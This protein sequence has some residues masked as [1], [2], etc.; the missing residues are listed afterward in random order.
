MTIAKQVWPDRT[1]QVGIKRYVGRFTAPAS[2]NGA[3]LAK[4]A[5]GRG[6]TSIVSGVAGSGIYTATFDEVGEAWLGCRLDVLNV[7]AGYTT[8]KTANVTAYSNT[9]KTLTFEVTN[10]NGTSAI[11]FANGDQLLFECEWA[12]SDRP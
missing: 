5:G 3:V 9:A 8:H 1:A 10:Y 7:G 6:I 12:D 11:D 2:A 4:T